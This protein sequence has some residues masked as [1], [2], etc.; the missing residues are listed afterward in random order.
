MSKTA[1]AVLLIT[2]GLV[3]AACVP[4][5]DPISDSD[6]IL[7]TWEAVMDFTDRNTGDVWPISP[8]LA[9]NDDG[10]VTWTQGG[11][12]L[13]SSYRW[14]GTRIVINDTFANEN[15]ADA[16][17]RIHMILFFHHGPLEEQTLKGSASGT[18]FNGEIEVPFIGTASA[19]RP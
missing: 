8:F 6:G 18:Y 14:S 9:F 12:D 3:I 1:K 7:G 5:E 10:T 11:V 2:L 4:S 17:I 19:R 13:F 16:W 15:Y